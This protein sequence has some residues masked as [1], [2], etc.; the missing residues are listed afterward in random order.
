MEDPRGPRFDN[1]SRNYRDLYEILKKIL[2]IEE[3]IIQTRSNFKKK[4][5]EIANIE[6]NQNLS[7]GLTSFSKALEGI[8]RSH[9]DIIL[10]LKTN[11]IETLKKFPDKLKS[12]KRSLSAQQKAKK[13]VDDSEMNIRN[14]RNEKDQRRINQE[15]L[16][17]AD[18]VF[19]EKKKIYELKKKESDN[20]IQEIDSKY[21]S[22][23]KEILTLLTY[24]KISFHAS[25]IQ[26]YSEAFKEILGI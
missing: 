21:K 23:V 9:R 1:K 6:N 18:T 15:D 4:W 25:A 7:N 26:S 2:K 17:R 22:D 24:T 19:Q 8:E 16:K 3:S 11:V 13:D 10:T 5:L 12:Q 20:E 14:I